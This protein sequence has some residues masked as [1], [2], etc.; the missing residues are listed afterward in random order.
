MHLTLVSFNMLPLKAKEY[1][2]LR[3]FILHRDRRCEMEYANLTKQQLIDILEE[4]KILNNQLLKEKEQEIGLDF[5]WTGNLGHWYWNIKTNNV[6]FNPLKVTTLGYTKEEIP[7]KVT[8]QFFTELL[9]PE[10]YQK[11]MVAMTNHLSKKANVYEVEYRI[12]TKDGK[13]KWYY[14]RGKI[15]KYDEHG[16]PL[17]L[18]G[19]VFD[20]TDKKEIQLELE[21]NNKILAELSSTDS[22]TNV[23]N[24]RGIM[25]CLKSQLVYAKYFKEPLSLV[26]FD[27]DDFK[28]VNDERGHLFGDKVLIEVAQI[29]KNNLDESDIAGRYGGEEFMIILP[30]SRLDHAISIAE[31]VRQAIEKHNFD[32]D[33]K[34]SVSGGVKEYQ[35]EEL[36]DFIHGADMNLYKAK[37]Q[38]KNLIVPDL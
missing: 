16:K 29:V 15:T 12:R 28:K 25:D 4:L 34:I 30:K 14:D 3:C 23:K 10:D 38:G 18:A 31:R 11:T 13:Y 33:L 17:F 9:H 5:P 2:E 22:L 35:G 19:I 7:E 24:R 37:K 27:I 26:I 36:R 20:I 32:T 8:Y 6:V 21:K 1:F